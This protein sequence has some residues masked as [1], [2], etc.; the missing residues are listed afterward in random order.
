MAEA[1]PVDERRAGI[2]LD[3]RSIV[4]GTIIGLVLLAALFA[5]LLAPYD[6][7]AQDLLSTLLPPSFAVFP[8]SAELLECEGSHA[9]ASESSRRAA[10]VS[11][12]FILK[13]VVMVGSGKSRA[14]ALAR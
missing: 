5:P 14:G 6:P 13:F 1:A 2:R 12:R 4:G 11:S 10:P 7:L 3:A 8:A 9:V